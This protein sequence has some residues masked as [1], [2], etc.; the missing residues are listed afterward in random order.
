[1]TKG[2]REMEKSTAKKR[3]ADNERRFA[4]ARAKERTRR[5]SAQPVSDGPTEP[6]Q[7]V[8]P[9]ALPDPEPT[10]SVIVDHVISRSSFSRDE[11]ATW[12]QERMD[13]LH[14]GEHPDGRLNSDLAAKAADPVDLEVVAD[15]AQRSRPEPEVTFLGR[16]AGGELKVRER[17]EEGWLRMAGS[18]ERTKPDVEPG[19]W[20]WAPAPGIPPAPLGR[21]PGGVKRERTVA[22]KER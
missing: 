13:A 19:T 7:L 5:V 18:I 15:W 17:E 1:M 12:F 8:A 9:P 21:V 10:P 6:R 16:L 4:A 14:R 2:G 22:G 3:E 20:W 11:A